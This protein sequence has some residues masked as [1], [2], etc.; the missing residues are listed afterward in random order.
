MTNGCDLLQRASTPAPIWKGV[1][2]G[3]E[4][5]LFLAGAVRADHKK[6]ELKFNDI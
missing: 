1:Q 5:H 3:R 2:A 6:L 4:S